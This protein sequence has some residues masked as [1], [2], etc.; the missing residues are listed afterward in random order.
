MQSLRLRNLISRSI[1]YSDF[2]LPRIIKTLRCACH[3]TCSCSC[4]CQVSWIFPVPS[5]CTFYSTSPS[6]K[7]W[8]HPRQ[9]LRQMS[10]DSSFLFYSHSVWI[11]SVFGL[12]FAH[13]R[14]FNRSL[15]YFFIYVVASIQ[16]LSKNSSIAVTL[17]VR[18]FQLHT[19]SSTCTCHAKADY[20]II[21]EMQSIIGWAWTSGRMSHGCV[22]VHV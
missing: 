9:L 21:S 6:Q 2:F 22:T 4:L 11:R 14:L 20:A 5:Y 17:S 8:T 12:S 7:Q 13:Q 18:F 19:C 1:F 16:F 3:S 15:L 10:Y